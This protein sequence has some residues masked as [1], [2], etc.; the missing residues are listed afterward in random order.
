MGVL[1]S[2][3]AMEFFR[4]REGRW[5]SRRVTHHLA[6]RRSE[7]GASEI[8]MH[9]LDAEDARIVQLCKDH[10]VDPTLASGGCH[11]S[12]KATLA[13]DQEGENHEGSTVFALVP[14]ADNVRAGKILRDRG[15]AEIVPIAGRY[16]MTDEDDLSLETPYE[17][18][19]VE[20]TFAFDS[21]DVCNRTSTVRRFGGLANATFST[22]TRLGVPTLAETEN[23]LDEMQ[24]ELDDIFANQLTF[25]VGASGEDNTRLK[26]DFLPATQQRF[27]EVAAMR[28]KE[29]A[30]PSANSAFSG[31]FG[32]APAPAAAPAP[33]KAKE[34]SAVSVAARRA[35]IDLSKVPPSMRAE[36][37]AS[38][39]KDSGVS[40]D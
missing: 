7:S 37:M 5:N 11:V 21:A 31:G 1:K 26:S 8:E 15:Y 9:C 33:E 39:E 10:K 12:W 18:G 24:W 20:E 2:A 28:A 35:G 13:W 36:F 16:S 6:F 29:G 40:A 38:L 19:A 3:D 30:K 4:H 23:N 27:K 17:G 22:E 14:D 25:G 34:E 32:A